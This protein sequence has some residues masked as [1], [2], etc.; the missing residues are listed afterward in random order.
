[1]RVVDDE[2]RRV[3]QQNRIDALE[4]DNLFENLKM[5]E[6]EEEGEGQDEW[7]DFNSAASDQDVFTTKKKGR[8][9]GGISGRKTR[10]QG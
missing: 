2:T 7:D 10:S 5:A 4:A 8:K 6:E 3:I 1:M 9:E